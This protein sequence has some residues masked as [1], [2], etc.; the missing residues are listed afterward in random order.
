MTNWFVFVYLVEIRC[1][2]STQHPQLWACG[3]SALVHSMKFN[4]STLPGNARKFKH[5]TAVPLIIQNKATFPFEYFLIRE[6]TLI[7]HNT[8]FPRKAESL[9][10]FRVQLHVDDI[11]HNRRVVERL[12]GHFGGFHGLKNHLC[13]SQVLLIFGIVKDLHL[14]DVSKFLAHVGKKSFPDVVVQ[15][16]ECHLLWRNSADVTLIDLREG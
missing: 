10:T 4:Y 9:F 14:L 2:G 13:N 12:H 16:G 3:S 11:S 5:V 6:K 15:P 7:V 1:R 8:S